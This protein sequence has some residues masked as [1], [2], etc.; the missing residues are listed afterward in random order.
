LDQDKIIYIMEA[1]IPLKPLSNG[2]NPR[3]AEEMYCIRLVKS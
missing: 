3:S 2:L 1:V